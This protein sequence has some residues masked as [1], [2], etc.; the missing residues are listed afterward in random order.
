MH[1]FPNGIGEVISEEFGQRRLRWLEIYP[2]AEISGKSS[3]KHTWKI[4][5]IVSGE[6]CY[7]K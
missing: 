1:H 6:H 3:G 4:V 7:W 2:F 5:P